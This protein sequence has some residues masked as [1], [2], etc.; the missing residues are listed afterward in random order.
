[1]EKHYFDTSIAP[2]SYG[3][4]FPPVGLEGTVECFTRWSEG[5]G[6]KIFVDSTWGPSEAKARVSKVSARRDELPGLLKPQNG[7]CRYVFVP[8]KSRWTAVL[9]PHCIYRFG[10]FS[11]TDRAIRDFGFWAGRRLG[12]S[13]NSPYCV[14]VT[15]QPRV[16]AGQTR[17]RHAI[18]HG[19]CGVVIRAA[20]PSEGFDAYGRELSRVMNGYADAVEIRSW[21]SAPMETFGVSDAPDVGVE[22]GLHLDPSPEEVDELWERFNFDHIDHICRQLGIEV[23]DDAFYGTSGY[24]IEMWGK[25][26]TFYE[27]EDRIPFDTYQGYCGI[28]PDGI[29]AWSSRKPSP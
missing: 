11:D 2:I 3:V 12:V 14:T 28:G 13:A 18:H 17:G 25:D 16:T 20:D 21:T 29:R 6:A 24:L 22:S 8:T 27:I 10:G 1:M 26:D 4:T 19:M 5:E 7:I 9:S 23:F 15:A